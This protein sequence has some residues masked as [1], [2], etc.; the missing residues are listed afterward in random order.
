MW[1]CDTRDA[2]R[3]RERIEMIC[4]GLSRGVET[5]DDCLVFPEQVGQI[6][7]RWRTRHDPNVSPLPSEGIRQSLEAAL[8]GLL[9]SSVTKR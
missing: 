5:P 4:N 2:G 8:P 9:T 7:G 6:L 1:E 3:L